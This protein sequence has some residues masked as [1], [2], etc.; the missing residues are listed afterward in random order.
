MQRDQHVKN[1]RLTW[2][3]KQSSFALNTINPIRRIIDNLKIEPNPEKHM[4]PL[5]IGEYSSRYIHFTNKIFKSMHLLHE[6]YDL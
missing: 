2:N 3:V 6:R 1:A 4:I 5:S